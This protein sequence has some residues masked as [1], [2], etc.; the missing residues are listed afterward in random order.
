MSLCAGAPGFQPIRKSHGVTGKIIYGNGQTERQQ[1]A[2]DNAANLQAYERR[3]TLT[4]FPRKLIAMPDGTKLSEFTAWCEK[5]IT[6]DE[7][8]QAQ[9]FL[10]RL[11]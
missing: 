8:G 4:I 3:L 6:S 10:D 9:I 5:H 11:L 7:K 2:P 1:N